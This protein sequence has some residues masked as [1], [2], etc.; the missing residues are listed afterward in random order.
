MITTAG[1]NIRISSEDISVLGRITSG[2]KLM[3]IS[4]E[5]ISVASITKVRETV[6]E[7]TAEESIEKTES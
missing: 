1:I 6:E 2:V 4:E 3:K 5:N 7:E